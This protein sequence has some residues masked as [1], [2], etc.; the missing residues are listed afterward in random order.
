M[1]F[2]EFIHFSS[3][4]KFY[5]KHS[6]LVNNNNKTGL[7]IYQRSIIILLLLYHDKLRYSY[8]IQGRLEG[9]MRIDGLGYLGEN[10][11]GLEMHYNDF[12]TNG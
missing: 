9:R 3:F 12:F 6:S 8:F 2:W 1:N 7:L 10:F 5:L 4:I 11:F